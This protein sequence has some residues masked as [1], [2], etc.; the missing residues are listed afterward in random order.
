MD[1]GEPEQITRVS[2]II[3]VRDDPRLLQCVRSVL[4]RRDEVDELEVIVV[5]HRCSTAFRAEVL[6]CLPAGARV[7]RFDGDTVYGARERGVD[8]AGGQVLFF[9]DADC[10]IRPGW[11][12]EA[13]RTLQA[14]AD[15]AQGFSGS[16]ERSRGDLLMQR[17][18]EA[19]LKRLHP[20]VGTEC[21]TRNLAVR[22][23]VF[24]RVN[25]PTSWRR[26]GDTYLGLL[27]EAN[28]FTVAYSH[29]MRVD[30]A[31]NTDLPVFIAKQ[32]CHGW[33]AQRIMQEHPE[34]Q[35]HGGHLRLVAR[36]ARSSTRFPG[37]RAV[38]RL[39]GA[40]MV[41]AA[42]MIE[43]TLP[44]IPLPVAAAA[45]LAADKG[46]ALAG[47]L[48]FEAGADEPRLSDLLGQPDL[49]G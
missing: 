44:V 2:V 33:G 17:R 6:A 37:Q 28:G 36:V 18:Y 35:W 27:A 49:V 16:L 7:V 32:I 24:D 43:R 20:G 25:F 29:A 3:P 46:G 5:D 26:T 9:T 48:L 4:A 41:R 23:G 1:S 19:H 8:E 38:A 21:D 10:V 13:L 34:V 12:A 47:H 42:W 11:I 39:L 45:L 30:H 40:G 22:R 14:G 31:H 15:L